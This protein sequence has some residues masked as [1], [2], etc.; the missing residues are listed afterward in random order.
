MEKIEGKTR[1]VWLTSTF[2]IVRR[3]TA[4]LFSHS[5]KGTK[6]GKNSINQQFPSKR[7]E[8][9]PKYFFPSAG[10]AILI[11]NRHFIFFSLFLVL[12]PQH[13]EVPRLGVELEL[14]LPTY[15]TATAMPDLSC[16]CDLR[17]SS[18]QRQIFN[19]LNE[20]MDR[21]LILMDASGVHYG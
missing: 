8:D 14:Q 4:N 21:T 18:W 9:L 10:L 12:H 2:K 3:P 16:I 15:T 6:T 17:H 19:S 11:R 20:A 7:H 1:N 13:T 5:Q